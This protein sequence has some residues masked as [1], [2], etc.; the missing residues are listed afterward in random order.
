MSTAVESFEAGEN[1]RFV[2]HLTRARG[3]PAA[4]MS[5]ELFNSD[6]RNRYTFKQFRNL[7]DVFVEPLR[8]AIEAA[9]RSVGPANRIV[10]M[11]DFEVT[12][13]GLVIG[14]LR[15]LYSR[16][17]DGA[18][19]IML[20]LRE[21][22][23]AI[24]SAFIFDPALPV[25]SASMRE[26]IAIEVLRDI[27]TPLLDI[28]S[29][30]RDAPP[31]V[32]ETNASAIDRQLKRMGM[33]QDEINFYNGLLKRYIAGCRSDAASGAANGLEAPYQNRI[34]QKS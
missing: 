29:I 23:G 32:L 7:S 31:Y 9:L 3:E 4:V 11:P 16:A 1:D 10:S 30:A 13:P 34:R 25:S 18:E 21:Y 26:R 15:L 27:V 24:K 28:L 22:V 8:S 17:E 2:V 20:R 14:G 6:I 5:V 19:I 33:R 12:L